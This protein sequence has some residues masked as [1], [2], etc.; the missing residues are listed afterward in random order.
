MAIR[1]A[2]MI[3]SLFTNRKIALLRPKC[4]ILNHE[5]IKSLFFYIDFSCYNFIVG[6]W[7]LT[8]EKERKKSGKFEV[9]IIE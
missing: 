5:I 7:A 6:G 2:R 9:G 3:Q 1:K 4:M 8:L